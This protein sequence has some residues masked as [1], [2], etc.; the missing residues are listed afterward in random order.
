MGARPNSLTDYLDL[1][2]EAGAAIEREVESEERQKPGGAAENVS[3]RGAEVIIAQLAMETARTDAEIVEAIAGVEWE[4]ADRHGEPEI[5]NPHEL[6]A[7]LPG[8]GEG[9]AE[10]YRESAQK[11]ETLF[12]LPPPYWARMAEAFSP[13]LADL[14][15][16][17]CYRTWIA[18]PSE[19]APPT[20]DGYEVEV[21]GGGPD[22]L[23]RAALP[24]PESEWAN[25]RVERERA[26]GVGEDQ[27]WPVRLVS[28]G[29]IHTA[30]LNAGAGEA[31][32]RHP[33][34]PIIRAWQ[35]RPKE[36]QPYRP[37]YRASLP[38]LHKLWA[39]D[40][41]RLPA[42]LE[43]DSLPEQRALPGFGTVV[44]SCPSWL[45]WMFD[46]AGGESMKHGRGAPWPMRLFV[47]SL[48]HLAVGQRDGEW[49]TLRF[50]TNDVIGWLHPN[51]WANKRRDWDKFP[52][53][54]DAIRRRLSYVPVPGIGSVAIVIPSVIPRSPT[55]PL[56]EFTIRIP[57]SAAH[58]ARLDWPFL[59]SLGTRSAPL[60]RA[61]LAVVSYWDRSAHK[62]HP[63]TAEI[64]APIID[65]DG[66]PIRRKGG[67]LVRS[68]HEKVAN[69]AAR[70]SPELTD[71]D[72]A[73]MIGFAPTD[74]RRRFDARRA[75]ERLAANGVIDLRREAGGRKVRIFGIVEKQA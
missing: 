75:F 39:D 66:R 15:R 13:T 65:K 16:E 55:D 47:G 22:V 2:L 62:G 19:G 5:P 30:W 63:I 43:A 45:L 3:E 71:A 26:R 67:S 8:S 25:A 28:L 48:L 12:P 7:W 29:E 72:L 37:A 42:N 68:V 11:L 32:G 14:C 73:R 20:R 49:R 34:A 41:A 33:L 21:G 10:R 31:R 17:N 53:A 70:F 69:P 27:P 52:A 50:P 9:A 64:P 57:S 18:S 1:T 36:T 51:G 59:C 6:A 56:V 4:Q 54:L 46:Q 74:K 40:G 23:L 35:E 38:R 58:G 44:E 24:L 60:Y 61:Y